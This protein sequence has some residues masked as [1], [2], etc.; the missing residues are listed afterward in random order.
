MRKVSFVV[1]SCWLLCFVSILYAQEGLEVSARTDH[2]LMC[3]LDG[4]RN[5]LFLE[6]SPEE[7]GAA[8]GE[9]YADG[10][11]AMYKKIAMVGMAFT[12]QK[13]VSFI[14]KVHEATRRGKGYTPKRFFDEMDACA[15]KAG[16]GAD[17]LYQINF[18]S[19]MFHCSGVALRGKATADGKVRHVRVLD[20]MRDIGL[21]DW[22]TLMVFMPKDYNA[23]IS[24]TYPGFI[25]TVSC[26]NERGLAMGEMGGDGEGK[27]DGLSMTFLMRRVMEECATVDEAIALLKAQPLTCDYYYVLSDKNGDMATICA[28][29]GS[30]NPVAVIRP[31]E[32]Y[33]D[34]LPRDIKLPKT[35]ED[36]VYVSGK[37]E[38]INTLAERLEQNY[39]KIDTPTLIEII[40]RP[41]CMKANLHNVIFE[42]ES[43]DFWFAEA[44]KETVA[45]DEKYFK[46]NIT[47]LIQ[48]YREHQ[49]D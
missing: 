24:V 32:Q 47:E 6:G 2:G 22:A 23:W 44:G 5:V 37:G 27:W 38:R 43:L 25:G 45:A 29:S 9:L 13:K 3:K 41:V 12:L 34:G 48:F 1:L 49:E 40:K 4:V 18:F 46:G 14:D 11:D 36:I 35:F 28:I 20:Y 19:E 42:P 33:P 39:G 21:Q 16:L 15:E 8:H 30:E 17:Y 31:N 10:I 7:M 26:M